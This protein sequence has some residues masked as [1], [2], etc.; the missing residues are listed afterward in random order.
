MP[1][2]MKRTNL[3]KSSYSGYRPRLDFGGVQKKEIHR[4]KLK[5][6]LKMRFVKI[7]IIFLFIGMVLLFR[8]NIIQ[9]KLITAIPKTTFVGEGIFIQ[10]YERCSPRIKAAFNLPESRFIS[11]TGQG[12][13]IKA[14][15]FKTK[16]EIIT[17][18]PKIT[19]MG[20]NIFVQ[21]LKRCPP[22]FKLSVL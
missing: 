1:N 19:I 20:R 5:K 2:R 13:L 6:P 9:I 17:L 22:R 11:K 21:S 8:H 12:Y 18:K 10:T 4:D 7:L 14:S 15:K 16:L 3:K